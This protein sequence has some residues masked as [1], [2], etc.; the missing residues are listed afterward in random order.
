MFTDAFFNPPS[1]ADPNLRLFLRLHVA[2]DYASDAQFKLQALDALRA[3]GHFKKLKM[4]SE[5]V[6]RN[7]LSENLS[8]LSLYLLCVLYQVPAAVVVGRTYF[9]V[10]APTH[11]VRDGRITPL[12]A[13]SDLLLVNPSKLYYAVSHYSLPDLT[14]MATALRVGLGTKAKM[15]AEITTCLTETYQRI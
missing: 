10:G 9:V 4:P 2:S 15:Y 6:E 14:T 7:L 1:T 11:V 3:G 13:A 12:F 8:P 5:A